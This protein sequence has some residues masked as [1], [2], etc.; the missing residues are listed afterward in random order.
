MTSGPTEGRSILMLSD[1]STAELAEVRDAVQLVVVPVGS[2]EQHGPN[3]SLA[4]DT[5]LVEAACRL[6]AEALYPRVLLS[7]AVPWGISD[8]HMGFVGTITLTPNTLI[9][10]VLDI[11]NSLCYHGFR[12]IL[13]VN[14]HSGNRAALEMAT[15][16]ACRQTGALFVGCCQYFDL[17]ENRGAGH[18][19]QTEVSYAM[20]LA[21]GIVKDTA[22]ADGDLVGPAPLAGRVYVPW[23]TQGT[24]R[25][26]PSGPVRGASAE[27]GR[28]LL[29][30][31]I[32]GLIEVA[33]IIMEQ[34]LTVDAARFRDSA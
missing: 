17:G 23:P 34:K 12:R 8:H 5:V 4:A 3:L 25:N 32:Q 28:E 24:S 29:D 7:P 26:G 33:N 10:L 13:L 11:V 2:L 27:L 18:A 31:S 21:P 16:M 14:G 15:A 6:V 1:L 20:H 22:L 19:A 30:S 9:S